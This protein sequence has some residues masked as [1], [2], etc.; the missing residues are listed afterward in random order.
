[1]LRGFIGSE[2]ELWAKVVRQAGLA[3]SEG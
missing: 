3:G 2:I 1:M